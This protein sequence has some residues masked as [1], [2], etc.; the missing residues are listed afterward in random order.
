MTLFTWIFLGLACMGAGY[1]LLGSWLL[2][3][4]QKGAGTSVGEGGQN[5]RPPGNEATLPP[6]TFLRPVKPGV[7]R[8]G[9][10]IALLAGCARKGDQVLVGVSSR[11][12]YAICQPIPGITL[13]LCEETGIP[14]PKI[15]K[16]LQMA[17]QALHEHLIVTDSEA[18]PS[19]A[20]FDLLRQDWRE[21]DAVTA[22]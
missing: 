19:A 17:P 14:N 22:G 1:H 6:V 12:D 4:W 21:G 16:L 11:E 7:P 9:E 2:A 10:K 5:V 20:F 13:V 3:R 18:L 15:N 8:L